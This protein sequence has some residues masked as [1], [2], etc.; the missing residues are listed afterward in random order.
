MW[1]YKTAAVS[2]KKRWKL[3]LQTTLTMQQW[4]DLWSI[5]DLKAGERYGF[6]TTSVKNL[7]TVSTI[8]Q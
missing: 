1:I 6:R 4:E 7:R 5:W 2:K 8:N 3:V